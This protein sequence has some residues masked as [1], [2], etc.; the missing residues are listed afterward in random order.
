MNYMKTSI[1]MLRG[2]TAANELH[3]DINKDVIEIKWTSTSMSFG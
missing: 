3:E 2:Q 1:K